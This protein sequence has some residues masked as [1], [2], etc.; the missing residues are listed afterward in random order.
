MNRKQMCVLVAAA[1]M[2]A[3]AANASAV[4]TP[5]TTAFTYQ[6]Q[7]DVGGSIANGTYQFTFTLYNAATAGAVVGTPIPQ[8]IQVING[9][10]TT[11]LDF[12]QIFSGAEYW[13]EIKVG[14]TTGNE[15]ALVA[16]QR[17][18]A[19]PVAQY[20]LNGNPGPVGATGATGPTGLQG[21]L[22][23][24][25]QMGA[26]GATGTV[27]PQ[28]VAG[29]PGAAGPTGPT[30]AQGAT[31]AAGS[32][33]IVTNSTIQTTY[34]TPLTT[35]VNY[36]GGT[37]T[38]VAPA[39]GTVLV[40]ANAQVDLYHTIGTFDVVQFA[41]GATPVDCGDPSHNI[42]WETPGSY[43]TFTS[44]QRT[45]TVTRS[46][47]VPSA[48]TYTYYLN[49]FKSTGGISAGRQDF[50]NFASIYAVYFHP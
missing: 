44:M 37:V 33:L 17:I 4:G 36:S 22:G 34:L 32:G 49:G 12:G 14:T 50:F 15:Q 6:G 30:G 46:F 43:P 25:G 41:I 8:A 38:L 18:N 16:R 3:A 28:G 47:T 13:L 35:C 48:G 10:F 26:T 19:V 2:S 42:T 24:T 45:F 21:P 39:S 27:G 1:L 31:G 40:T 23:P 29:A 5:Q 20:A 9:L 11:D 7:L